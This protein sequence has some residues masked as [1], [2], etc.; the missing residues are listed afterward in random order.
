MNNYQWYGIDDALPKDGQVVIIIVEGRQLPVIVRYVS[1]K[2][3]LKFGY[4]ETD[5]AN[6]H[7]TYSV[8][9]VLYWAEFNINALPALSMF[10][11]D[12]TT[13]D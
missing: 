13:V 5:C 7:Q 12:W 2:I 8:A 4:F 9:K 11:R 10:N 1:P 3:L 6:C